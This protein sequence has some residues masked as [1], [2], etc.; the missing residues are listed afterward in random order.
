MALICEDL[1]RYGVV[2][3]PPSG[4][5][6]FALLADI[7]HRLQNGPKGSPPVGNDAMDN[8]ASAILLNRALV[9][10]ASIAYIWSFRRSNDKITTRSYLPGTNPSVLLP[11]SLDDRA[12]EFDR[13]GILSF[14]SPSASSSPAGHGWATTPT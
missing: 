2:L 12:K 6:Y 3:I 14:P 9:A 13:I 10:I 11:F 4:A 8:S 7:E 1:A 5:G